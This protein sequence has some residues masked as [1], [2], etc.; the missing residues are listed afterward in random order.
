MSSSKE[1][2]LALLPK[3]ILHFK[4]RR[5]PFNEEKLEHYLAHGQ[6]G[7]ILEYYGY[8]GLNVV[9]NVFLEKELY[10]ELQQMKQ[11]LDRYNALHHTRHHL[12]IWPDVK[13]TLGL[14][15]Q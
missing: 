3:V 7:D 5:I 11:V 1:Q 6:Y 8:P 10:G 15:D 4:R 14:E 2:R 13:R 12:R 9:F